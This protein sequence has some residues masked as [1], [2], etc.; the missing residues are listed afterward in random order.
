MLSEE[1]KSRIRSEEI[2]RLEVSR[3]LE[4]ARSIASPSRRFWSL[5]NSSFALWFLSSVVLAS[6]TGWFANYESR[7][8]EENKKVETVRRLDT[9][10]ANRMS[11]ALAGLHLDEQRIKQHPTFPPMAI[12]GNI[13][14]YLDNS[15]AHNHSNPRDFSIYP[16]YRNR[17]FRSLTIELN[18]L[19]DS[20]ARIDLKEALAAYE[21]LADLASIPKK[22]LTDTEQQAEFAA[23]V[24]KS[25]QLLNGRLLKNRWRSYGP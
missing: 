14:L 16:E 5:L 25:Y 21:E 2:F 23:V 15:F 10:I 6:L 1:E 9:E 11:Q 20:S 13:V 3:E 17:S 7:R 12:Y 19:V 8:N 4:A 18:S 22:I 24:A